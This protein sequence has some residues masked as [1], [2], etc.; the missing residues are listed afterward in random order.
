MSSNELILIRGLP[1][2]GKT[3]MAKAMIGYIHFEADMQFEVDGIYVYDK[4]KIKAAHDWCVNS[5][6]QAL[7]EGKNVVVSNTFIKIWELKRYIDLGFNYKVIEAN[8][9]WQNVHGV[10]ED[11]IQIM[12]NNWEP[13]PIA[14]KGRRNDITSKS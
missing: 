8:G 2:S 5:A 11:R 4:S 14:L 10:T 7:K 9:R 6:Q 3:T 13:Y 12:R 1:G